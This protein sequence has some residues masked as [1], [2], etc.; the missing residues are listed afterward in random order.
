MFLSAEKLTKKHRRFKSV[1]IIIIVVIIIMNIIP[2][3]S[4]LNPV[5]AQLNPTCHLL[6]ILG[7]HHILHV[8]RIGVNNRVS[9]SS[10][11]F[12]KGRPSCPLA[13]GLKFSVTFAILKTKLN[14]VALVRERTIPTERPP[15]VGEV[16]AN[17]CG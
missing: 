2:H 4:H 16:S 17:F 5:N 9:G 14:S 13:C 3:E 7:A 12:F 1:Q 6:A 15:P 8:S 10:N 11:S